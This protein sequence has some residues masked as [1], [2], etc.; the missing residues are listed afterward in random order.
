[1][2]TNLEWLLYKEELLWWGVQV[3]FRFSPEFYPLLVSG[4]ILRLQLGE[5]KQQLAALVTGCVT[6]RENIKH[7]RLVERSGRTLPGAG[8]HVRWNPLHYTS[9]VELLYEV[10][11]RLMSM[12]PK[13]VFYIQSYPYKRTKGVNI[14]YDY[15]SPR[16]SVKIGHLQIV[17]AY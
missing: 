11:F 14:S 8:S 4:I 1:M 16:I 10:C 12:C 7:Q 17:R 5:V 15:F 9:L 6:P 13:C 2:W 3:I